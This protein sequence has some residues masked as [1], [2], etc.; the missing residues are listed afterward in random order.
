M[1]HKVFYFLNEKK[2]MN[3]FWEKYFTFLNTYFFQKITIQLIFQNK[4]F[5][6]W[7]YFWEQIWKP[8]KISI[9]PE[10]FTS[11][12]TS[13]LK[14]TFTESLTDDFSYEQKSSSISQIFLNEIRSDRRSASYNLH[15]KVSVVSSN[16]LHDL[17]YQRRNALIDGERVANVL[18]SECWCN[19]ELI[20]LIFFVYLS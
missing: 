19:I 7:L 4:R 20:Y 14:M 17:S 3:Q 5:W 10:I 1:I 6:F 9:Q 12:S 13:F 2:T 8:K 11:Y 15:T 18:L 16:N